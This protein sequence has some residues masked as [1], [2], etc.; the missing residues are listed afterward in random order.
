MSLIYKKKDK[1]NIENYRPITLMNTDYKLYTKTIANKLGIIAP[2]IINESQAGFIPGRGL[3][4]HTRTTHTVIEYC[5]LMGK[6][7][8]IISLDQEKA[9]DKIDHQYLWRIM[10]KNEFPE[11]FITKIK[12]LYTQ[13]ETVVMVNGVKPKPIPVERGVRQGC[14]MSCILYN[15]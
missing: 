14:P 1:L 12:N 8:C 15:I 2:S 5:D 11:E 7:G 13:A 9:Y 6:D 3:Y 10:E 4:D